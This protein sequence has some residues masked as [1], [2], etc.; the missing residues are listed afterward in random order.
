MKPRTTN[1][2]V[3]VVVDEEDDDDDGRRSTVVV[4][5]VVVGGDSR[6]LLVQDNDL[7]KPNLKT[8]SLLYICL[9]CCLPAL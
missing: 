2:H 4:V 9:A 7:T 5:V 3:D 8:H 6:V 1:D